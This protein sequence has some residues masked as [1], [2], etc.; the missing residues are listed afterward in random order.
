[1]SYKYQLPR[2][3][4]VIITSSLA[5]SYDSYLMTVGLDEEERYDLVETFE[6][7]VN[8][9]DDD[10]LEYM[11]NEGIFALDSINRRFKFGD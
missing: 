4:R 3:N 6:Q 9:L 11:D 2:I 8:Q 7:A 1:M 10:D 5:V